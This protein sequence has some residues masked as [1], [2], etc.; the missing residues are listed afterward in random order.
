MAERIR[1]IK[2]LE[3]VKQRIK[4]ESLSQVTDA[5]AE[6]KDSILKAID[7]IR[8]LDEAK[9]LDALNGAVKQRGVITE[10]LPLN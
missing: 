3:K 7:L 1:K 6:N 5:I 8:T 4:A 10:K 9:I 2:R